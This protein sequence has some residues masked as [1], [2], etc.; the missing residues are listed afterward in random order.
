MLELLL[1][2]TVVTQDEA[3]RLATMRR[4]FEVQPSEES[5]SCRRARGWNGRFGLTFFSRHHSG[6][7]LLSSGMGRRAFGSGTWLCASTANGRPTTQEFGTA[8]YVI[9]VVRRRL[10][11]SV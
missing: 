6:R 10:T 11:V 7:T 2:N 9:V 8:R 1:G 3:L 4:A 5:F